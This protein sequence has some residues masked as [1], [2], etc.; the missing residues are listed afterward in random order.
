VVVSFSAAKVRVV[1]RN[2]GASLLF[3]CE[4]M[5]RGKTNDKAAA[6]DE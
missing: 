6:D 4:G 5:A 1:V 3:G 2:V